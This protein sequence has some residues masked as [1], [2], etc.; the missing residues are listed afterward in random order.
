MRSTKTSEA[1]FSSNCAVVCLIAVLIVFPLSAS[2]KLIS[3]DDVDWE[4]CGPNGISNRARLFWDERDFWVSQHVG[5]KMI[6]EDNRNYVGGNI[7]SYCSSTTNNEKSRRE[8]ILVWQ[9]HFKNFSRC[10]L[11]ARQMCQ[12]HGACR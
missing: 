5:I 2:A 1:A 12:L 9:N 7:S 8:C 3:Y 6:I 10:A 4:T 11:H